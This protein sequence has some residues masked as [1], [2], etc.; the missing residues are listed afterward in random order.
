MTGRVGFKPIPTANC[1]D[2]KVLFSILTGIVFRF[3]EK[4]LSVFAKQT[5]SS[6]NAAYF[7]TLLSV[8]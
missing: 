8:L 2:L 4:I 6:P 5:T 1:F 3:K 7:H